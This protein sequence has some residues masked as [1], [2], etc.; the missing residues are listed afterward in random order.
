ML[1]LA[2]ALLSVGCEDNR[3]ADNTRQSVSKKSKAHEQTTVSVEITKAGKIGSGSFAGNYGVDLI[4]TNYRSTSFTF[5]A[6]KCTV[7][8]EDGAIRTVTRVDTTSRGVYFSYHE[9]YDPEAFAR[10]GGIVPLSIPPLKGAVLDLVL[11]V[12][13]DTSS[14]RGRIDFEFYTGAKVVA[15]SSARF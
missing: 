12:Y 13:D 1:I 9:K 11:G 2:T 15:R 14:F 3:N 6:M 5:D 7:H 8:T 4:V 10:H